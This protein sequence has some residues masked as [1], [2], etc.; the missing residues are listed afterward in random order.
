MEAGDQSFFAYV[1][2]GK[3]RSMD[4]LVKFANHL[5][6]GLD[7]IHRRDMIHTDIKFGNMVID[8]SLV[9]NLIDFDRATPFKNAST[10]S[11]L[12]ENIRG[13]LEY[14]ASELPA[15]INFNEKVDS[16]FK[17]IKFGNMVIDKSL[18]LKLINFDRATPFKNAS[19]N[20]SLKEN[21]RGTLEYE[22]SELPAGINFNEKVDSWSVGVVLAECVLQT[23][24]LFI[25]NSGEPQLTTLSRTLGTSLLSWKDFFGELEL[26]SKDKEGYFKFFFW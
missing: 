25:F 15:G 3:I 4:D 7:Y 10:N 24:N 12:K 22:A 18:V 21:I 16:C 11:S 23:K 2:E 26:F 19:T 8:E 5:F 13:T 17:D 9:L 1:E 6:S 20:S 14:E